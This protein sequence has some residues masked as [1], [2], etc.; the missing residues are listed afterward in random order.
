MNRARPSSRFQFGLAACLAL[1]LAGCGFQLRDALVLPPD[2]GPVR[3]QAA[4]PYSAL[5]QSLTQSLE[6]AGAV[7]VRDADQDA[8]VLRILSEHWATTPISVDQFGRAQEFSLRYA[9]VFRLDRADE[10]VLVPQQV[11]ELSRDYV[12]PPVDSIG[13][14]SEAELLARELRR[15]MAAAVLRRIDA[16]SREPGA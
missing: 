2:L 16:V 14:S 11:I 1:L 6:R 3:L 4:D 7:I 9:V 13:R 12:A 5:L 15:E 10:S 8:A